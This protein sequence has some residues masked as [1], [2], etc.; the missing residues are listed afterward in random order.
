[1]VGQARVTRYR[2]R[3]VQVFD[4]GIDQV[5]EVYPGVRLSDS[6][7]EKQGL[8]EADKHHVAAV[9]NAYSCFER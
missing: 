3:H 1:M 9:R 7:K 8:L 2:S 4:R 5:L 6:Y